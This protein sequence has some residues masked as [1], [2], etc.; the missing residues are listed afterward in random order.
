MPLVVGLSASLRGSRH[1]LGLRDLST[2]LKGCSDITTLRSFL[3]AESGA[4]LEAF[5]AARA[6]G[7]PFDEMY[8]NL[9]RSS[10][11]RGLSNCEVALAGALWGALQEG[12]NCCRSASSN[13]GTIGFPP[14]G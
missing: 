4:L 7:V 5:K 14:G 10:G 1:G 13:R 12:E 8:R 6:E 2:A 9:R 11:L 3:E